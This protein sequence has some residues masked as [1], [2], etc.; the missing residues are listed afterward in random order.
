MVLESMNKYDLILCISV[1]LVAGIL[2]I[3]TKLP[4]DGTNAIV[5]YENKEVLRIDLSI[6][7][8]YTVSGYNG[9]VTLEVKD[10]KIRVLDEVSPKHLCSKQGYI[11]NSYESIIC[12]PNKI[13]V[14]IDNNDIDA[15]VMLWN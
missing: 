3:L 9:D 15:V 11:S 12:L 5:Y 1:F 4:K 13:V 14:K 8:T 2:L 7:N 6:N 10:K